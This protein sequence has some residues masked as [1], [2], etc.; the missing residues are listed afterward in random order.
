[1]SDDLNYASFDDLAGL[2]KNLPEPKKIFGNYILENSL[3]LFPSER[4]SGKTFLMI[5]V[6]LS[7]ASTEN[8]FL[9]ELIELHG[10]A[11]F[12]NC[13][14]GTSLVARR[15]SK[16]KAHSS[17][18]NAGP[19]DAFMYTTRQNYSVSKHEI[20]KKIIELKPVLVVIDNWKT[21]F[22][23][24]NGNNNQDTAKAI[25]ELLNLKDKYSFALVIVDHTKKGTSG[26]A[27]HSDLQSGA[28]S[29]SDLVDQ[30]FLLRKSSKDSSFRLLKRTKSR[31][32]EEQ[33]N[34]KLLR[35]NSKSLWFEV[36]E[37]EVNEMDHLGSSNIS[38]KAE[39]IDKALSL[40]EK[41]FSY[42]Q[43]GKE[44]EKPASTVH[45]WLKDI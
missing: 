15:L 24:V 10:N 8:K 12:V 28:G 20:E 3:T 44:L 22:S 29:K 42:K 6:C 43:I 30:D 38:N 1:M 27:S 32:V 39:L 33:K 45:R 14:L 4:G 23:D 35:F 36:V 19:H 11:L 26:L 13:E 21:A 7:V 16:L 37:E 41:G 5:Q 17:F 18:T 2:G 31:M 25:V 40:K 9:G 34:P